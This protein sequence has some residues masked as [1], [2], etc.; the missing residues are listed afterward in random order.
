MFFLNLPIA[1]AAVTV[2]YLVVPRDEDRKD[3]EGI[4][5]LGMGVLTIGLFSLLWRSILA[6]AS[7]GPRPT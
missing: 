2:T 3:H 6:R 1:I 4:D 7:A 5:Y